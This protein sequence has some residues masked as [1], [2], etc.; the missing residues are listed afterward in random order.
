VGARTE[1]ER[2]FR[3]FSLVHVG[4]AHMGRSSSALGA[5][6]AALHLRGD[7][8]L[9]DDRATADPAGRR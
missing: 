3:L 8:R 4:D 9:P 5:F 1:Q 7:H 6:K 2:L